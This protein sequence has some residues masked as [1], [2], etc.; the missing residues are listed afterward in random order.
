MSLDQRS[1]DAHGRYLVIGYIAGLRDAGVEPSVGS[2]G[3]AYDCTLAGTIDVLCKTDVI[4]HTQLWQ[5]LR[6]VE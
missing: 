5:R 4:F 1:F 3:Y 2:R 6:G